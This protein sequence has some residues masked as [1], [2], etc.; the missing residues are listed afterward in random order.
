ME[1][2]MQSSKASIQIGIEEQQRASIAQM[3]S[4]V[5]A[6]EHVLYIKLRNYHWN[7]TGMFFQALHGLFED[8][9]D[10][11]AEKI[12]TVKDAIAYIEENI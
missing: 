7:V 12:V 3:L 11:I 10:D 8:Q 2:T 6:D 5:L 1:K 4:L 9:Y